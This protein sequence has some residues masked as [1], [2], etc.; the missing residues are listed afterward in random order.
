MAWQFLLSDLNGNTHGEVQQ[1]S[2]RKVGLPHLRVP[3]ASF[4]IPIW[5]SL[6]PTVMD[7]DCLLRA[8]RIDPITAT[9]TLAFHGPVISAEENAD[10]DAGSIAVTAAGPYWRLA[11]RLIPASKLASGVQYGSDVSFLDLGTIARSVLTD[12]NGAHF[13]GIDLGTFAASTSAWA[14]K[15]Y[16]KNAAEAIAELG[17]GLGS[18]EM[19]VRPTE[20]TSYASPSGWPRIGLFDVAPLIGGSRPDAIFEYGTDRANTS[21]YTRSV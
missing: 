20:A 11:K 21:S 13:T 5:H 1:A 8:Y 6:A 19:R 12:V 14:G 4:N 16:L 7:T 17:A 3:S 2:S 9:R 15:W 18:F 10:G